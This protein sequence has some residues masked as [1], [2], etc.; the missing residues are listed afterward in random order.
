MQL[1]TKGGLALVACGI[2]IFGGWRLW[3]KTRRFVPLDTP[4]SWNAGQNI[5]SEFSLN[6]DGVYLIEITA[7]QNVPIDTLHCLMDAQTDPSKCRDVPTA[8][9]GNWMLFRDGQPIASGSIQEPHSAP[10]RANGVARVI[11]K[12]QGKSGQQYRLQILFTADG[13]PL[14]PAHPHLRV[15]IA[16]IAYT[17]VQSEAVLV[18]SAAF[19][20]VLFGVILLSTPAYINQRV[21]NSDLNHKQ[22]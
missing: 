5:G 3:S 18:F 6:F 22:A 4:I 9:S 10:V 2:F 7:E 16:S 20:C 15:T 11:G 12:F 21:P 14:E 1:K 13:R 19:I 8:M 17:D